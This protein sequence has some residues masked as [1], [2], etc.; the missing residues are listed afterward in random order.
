MRI[1]RI[2]VALILVLILAF[3]MTAC[4]STKYPMS[5]QHEKYGRKA[6]EIVDAYLD[7]DLT[8]EEAYKKLDSLC[9][10]EGTLPEPKNKDE[11][12]GDTMIRLT[13]SNLRY[14]LRKAYYDGKTDGILEQRNKIADLLGVKQ[15]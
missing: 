9:D 8:A 13:V 12:H 15:R 10:A 3:A 6:L 4:S 7:F 1:T 14:D 2:I 11:E 5:E